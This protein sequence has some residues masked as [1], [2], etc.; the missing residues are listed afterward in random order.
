MDEPL[1]SLD[2]AR[3]EEILPFLDRLHLQGNIPI[4]YVSHSIDEIAR[5]CDSLV[6]MDAG[7]SALC[8][9]LQDVLLHTD[10]PVLGGAEAGAVINGS[11]QSYDAEFD[12]TCVQFSGGEFWVAGEQQRDAALRLRVRAA[13]VSLC[14]TRPESTTILNI[15][16]AIVESVRPESTT[17]N[18]ILLKLG[19]DKA[20][21]RITRRSTEELRLQ[22]GDEVFAQIKSVAVR[23]S[24]ADRAETDRSG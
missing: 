13:D 6:I 2:R 11:A 1:A 20:L 24:P 4:I 8:G 21:A 22:P 19:E 3:R 15:I 18:M 7:R 12:L 23:N 10:V 5:L 16:P 17:S 9:D 14:R